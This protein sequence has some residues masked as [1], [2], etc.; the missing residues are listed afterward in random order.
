ML[1]QEDWEPGM[2]NRN[3]RLLSCWMAG[4]LVAVIFFI[5]TPVSPGATISLYIYT[6]YR[7][8]SDYDILEGP[9]GDALADG[10]YVM[11]VGSAD[12]VM[13][14]LYHEGSNYQ[15]LVEND[16]ILGTFQLNTGNDEGWFDTG[17]FTFDSGVV[18]YVYLYFFNSSNYP[19]SGVTAYGHSSVIDA[20]NWNPVTYSIELDMTRGTNLY[21]SATNNFVVIPEPSSGS[22]LVLF[23]G[24]GII[25]MPGL[26][27]AC[28]KKEP[29]PGGGGQGGSYDSV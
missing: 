24:L 8:S 20:R 4:L 18:Q 19:V 22:L 5:L 17:G 10:S 12:N 28:S 26:L 9:N 14:D 29:R 11:V 15:S 13:E 6:Q 21:V 27:K 7:T 16:I 2:R 25:G 23:L 3:T 1:H